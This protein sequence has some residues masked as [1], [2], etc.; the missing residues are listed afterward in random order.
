MKH[1][2]IF[3]SINLARREACGLLMY[4]LLPKHPKAPF[5]VTKTPKKSENKYTQGQE[6]TILKHVD[7]PPPINQAP[8]CP[9]LKK[10]LWESLTNIND[11]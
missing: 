2:D 11:F 7:I 1:T 6:N 4:H 8:G 5:N 9:V 3:P 10:G